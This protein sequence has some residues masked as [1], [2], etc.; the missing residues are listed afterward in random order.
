VIAKGV[1][2]CGFIFSAIYAPLRETIK[3]TDALISFLLLPSE[4]IDSATV[5]KEP[6]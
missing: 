3:R 6:I 1:A 4:G 2:Q 5:Q